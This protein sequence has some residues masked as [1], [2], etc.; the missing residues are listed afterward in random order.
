MRGSF[1]AYQHQEQERPIELETDE[2]TVINE[3]D[4]D[5]NDLENYA[6]T[7]DKKIKE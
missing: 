1:C 6:D 4:M 5:T 2:E 7:N 3:A